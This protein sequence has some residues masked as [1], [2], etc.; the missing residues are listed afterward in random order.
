M[1]TKQM[2]D[3][4]NTFLKENDNKI[5]VVD[6]KHTMFSLNNSIYHTVMIDYYDSENGEIRND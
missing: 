5:E 6:I 4:V 2:E 3:E 1:N